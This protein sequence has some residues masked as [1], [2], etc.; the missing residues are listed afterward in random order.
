MQVPAWRR[1][2]RASRP[3]F[4]FA[5]PTPKIAGSVESESLRE[6]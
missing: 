6:V 5:S 4:G 2:V 3:E 1:I